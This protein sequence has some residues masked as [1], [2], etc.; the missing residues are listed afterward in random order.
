VRGHQNGDTLPNIHSHLLDLIDRQEDNTQQYSKLSLCK[1]DVVR[2]IF[3]SA[4]KEQAT[5]RKARM[6]RRR[7][8][9]VPLVLATSGADSESGENSRHFEGVAIY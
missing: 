1:I 2:Q 4:T 8:V 3:I 5:A 6:R 9:D 7:M